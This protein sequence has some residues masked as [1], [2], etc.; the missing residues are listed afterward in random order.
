MRNIFVFIPLLLFSFNT[1]AFEV[2]GLKSGITKTE[3]YELTNCQAYIDQYNIDNPPSRYSPARTKN[4]CINNIIGAI[5]DTDLDY[6]EGIAN[7]LIYTEWTHENK[8]WRIQI[9]YFKPGGILQGLA[10]MRALEEAFP[11]KEITE[12]SK[13]RQVIT[14]VDDTLSNGAIDH[15]KKQ[16]LEKI[17]YKK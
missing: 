9:F 11:G 17:N 15:Y 2:Y 6:F 12:D 8:L 14:F 1:Y 7:S 10:F 5:A 16:S 3:F 4:Y 13:G